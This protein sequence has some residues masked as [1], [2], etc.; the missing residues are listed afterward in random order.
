MGTSHYHTPAE[1]QDGHVFVVRVRR[2]PATAN[3]C[4]CREGAART[5]HCQSVVRC[6]RATVNKMHRMRG[7]IRWAEETEGGDG[8]TGCATRNG[9]SARHLPAAATCQ[10]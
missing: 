1:Q 5:S 2:G 7:A 3:Q 10:L 8:K 4:V 9:A 6:G